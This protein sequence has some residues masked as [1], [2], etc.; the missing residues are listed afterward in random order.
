[1]FSNAHSSVQQAIVMMVAH[2]HSGFT[3]FITYFKKGHQDDKNLRNYQDY[4]D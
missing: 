2:D 1:M 3:S 4:E